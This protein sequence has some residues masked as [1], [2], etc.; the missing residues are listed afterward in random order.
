MITLT[1][2]DHSSPNALVTDLYKH[3]GKECCFVNSD[4]DPITCEWIFESASVVSVGPSPQFIKNYGVQIQHRYIQ[5]NNLCDLSY[6]LEAG[7]LENSLGTCA[8]AFL[9]PPSC[10]S[11]VAAVSQIDKNL[12][13]AFS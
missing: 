11:V 13:E 9:C 1:L 5:S 8:V 2:L 6:R 10:A 12:Q 3:K 4:G 7:W